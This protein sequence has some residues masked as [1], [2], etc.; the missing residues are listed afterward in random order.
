MEPSRE[1]IQDILDY[2]NKVGDPLDDAEAREIGYRLLAFVELIARPRS[3]STPGESLNHG[4]GSAQR[5]L[6]F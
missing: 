4:R 2:Y 6:P 1:F 3:L 5:G